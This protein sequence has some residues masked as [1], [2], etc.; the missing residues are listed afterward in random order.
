MSI[1]FVPSSWCKRVRALASDPVRVHVAG[2]NVEAPG[3]CPTGGCKE[4]MSKTHTTSGLQGLSPLPTYTPNAAFGIIDVSEAEQ[5][6]TYAVHHPRLD[7]TVV[8]RPGDRTPGWGP[9]AWLTLIQHVDSAHVDVAAHCQQ[10]RTLPPTVST[11][12][13]RCNDVLKFQNRALISEM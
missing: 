7:T 6:I 4:T 10:V 2:K 8:V 12:V 9:R 3:Q 13:N 1:D 5:G 11:T